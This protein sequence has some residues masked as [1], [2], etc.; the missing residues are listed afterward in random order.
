MLLFLM[1]VVFSC[2]KDKNNESTDEPTEMIGEDVKLFSGSFTYYADAAVFQTN[3]ELFGVVENEM[4]MD[5]IVQAETLKD[6]ATDE[7]KVTLKAKVSKKPEG[8]E[9][10]E[11][12]IEIVE[13]I[14]VTKSNPED[15][16]IIKLGNKNNAENQ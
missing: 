11:N 15:N 5:L 7:V 2:K 14:K 13:I 3:N 6:E 16:T 10:W 1:G 8:E 12:R 4:L 9:G